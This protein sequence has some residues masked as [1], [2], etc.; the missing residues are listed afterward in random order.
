MPETDKSAPGFQKH[1]DYRVDLEPVGE[2]VRVVFAGQ[3]IAATEGAVRVLETKHDPVIYVPRTD[4]RFDCLAATD[5]TTYCPFK[6]D[7]RYWT[8]TVGDRRSENAVWG[9][10][11]PYDEVA[12]L[13]DYVAFYTSRVDSITIGD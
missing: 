1:P 9:Y 2:P 6:G 7:A 8:I 3:P 4:V 11:D 10:D 12:D 5:H 13:S